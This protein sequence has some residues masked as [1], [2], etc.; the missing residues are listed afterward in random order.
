MKD[1]STYDNLGGTNLPDYL[2]VTPFGVPEHFFLDQSEKITAQISIIGTTS[3]E[4]T[5][6]PDGYF[7]N[8]ENSI[9]ARV[10]QENLKSKVSETGFTV[11]L[12][13]FDKLGKNIQNQI[14]INPLHHIAKIDGFI[15]PI[16]YFDELEENILSTIQLD[17]L[18]KGPQVGLNVPDGYFESL[19]SNITTKIKESANVTEEV[20]VIRMPARPAWYKYVAASAIL[21]ISSAAYFFVD[22]QEE[23]D[24][25]IALERI[26]NEEIVNYLA[27]VGDEEMLMDLATSYQDSETKT[28]T[29]LDLDK[30]VEDKE[31]EEYL[32]YML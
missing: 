32:N 8:L 18:T 17:K 29:T 28:E 24:T 13:Y 1:E 10:A 16:T 19:S 21:F 9:L 15:T 25:K 12:D 2:R 26:S 22:R 30:E 4:N 27:Q 5:S 31:I 7:E 20:P 14:E 6:V 3:K 23:P 11:P